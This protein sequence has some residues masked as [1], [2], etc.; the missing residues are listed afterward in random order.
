MAAA[1][2]FVWLWCA[3][4]SRRLSVGLDESCAKFF[5]EC[6]AGADREDGE[7]GPLEF[8]G[9]DVVGVRCLGDHVPLHCAGECVERE[10]GG[11][12]AE[13]DRGEVG[14]E[15]FG[16]DLLADDGEGAEVCRGSGEEEDE[17]CAG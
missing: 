4:A 17:R 11:E 6:C 14:D 8:E 2:G 13:C 12:G 10:A 7:G 1:G 3:P 9:D 15:P 16:A 5:A